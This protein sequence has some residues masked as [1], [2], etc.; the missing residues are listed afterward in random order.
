MSLYWLLLIPL[1]S[2]T[3]LLAIIYFQGNDIRVVVKEL[4]QHFSTKPIPILDILNN[5]N[6]S[7]IYIYI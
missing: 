7:Y 2:F 6:L 5:P 4:K 3:E 1:S